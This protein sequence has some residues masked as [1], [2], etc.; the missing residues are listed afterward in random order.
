MRKIVL[1][2][3]VAGGL[4]AAGGQALAAGGDVYI[5]KQKWAWQGVFGT[6]DKA[7]LQRGF[8]VYNEVCSA[9]HSLNLVAYRNLMDIGLP[10]DA[11]K[12]IAAAK[13]VIDGPDDEGEMFE[14]EAR[15]SD[16][17]VAPFPNDNAARAANGG[18]LPPDLSLI[19]KARV[20]GPDYVYSLLTGF[21]EPPPGVEV[22]EGMN[23][24]RSFP[25]HQIAMPPQIYDDLVEYADGTPATAPQIA[26]DITAF[27]NW[28]AEPE[29]DDRKQLGMKVMLFLLVLTAL[30]Y[31]L[32][33]AIWRDVEH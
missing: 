7:Q 9:C 28:A 32:K 15:P 31:A 8:L 2:M 4:M 5:D 23:Y 21:V 6:Y 19:N 17:F 13:T 22:S 27:M 3:L 33:R 1:S 25:G 20:Y 12:A 30:L 14:R 29:L 16:R 10:E 24:N 18:A 11:V 26:K